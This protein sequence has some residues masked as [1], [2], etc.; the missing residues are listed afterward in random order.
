MRAEKKRNKEMQQPV[1]QYHDHF[2]ETHASA[3]PRQDIN[4][5]NVAILKYQAQ[6]ICD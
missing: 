5:H 1:A 2:D 4:V 6:Q 3:E